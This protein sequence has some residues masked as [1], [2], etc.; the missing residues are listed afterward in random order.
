ML[1]D[2][3]VEPG[4]ERDA[5]LL[6]Q[7][8]DALCRTAQHG[9]DRGSPSQNPLHQPVALL[10]GKRSQLDQR[11]DVHPVR[12]VG[13]NAAGGCMGMEE[14]ALLFEVAEGVPDGGR[15]NAQAETTSQRTRSGR[16]RR[17]YVALDHRLQNTPFP[18]GQVR[19]RH[20]SKASSVFR[21]LPTLG[22]ARRGG[23]ILRRLTKA[24]RSARP[25][26][27]TQPRPMGERAPAPTVGLPYPGP[28]RPRFA[29][30]DTAAPTRG[31]PRSAPHDRRPDPP[32]AAPAG[33]MPCTPRC[34]SVAP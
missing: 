30:P 14:I 9:L 26:R 18:F 16:L 31:S 27:P 17:L 22:P 1:E 25:A 15:R 4:A 13:W 34:S 24:A 8:A 33:P 2:D 11:I 29:T 7:D 21:D 32:R 12:P 5:Q 20:K 10:R 28:F 23:A 6:R 3:L 19:E